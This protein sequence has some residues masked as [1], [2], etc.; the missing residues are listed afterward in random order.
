MDGESTLQ[1]Y[2]GQ[3]TVDYNGQGTSKKYPGSNQISFINEIDTSDKDLIEMEKQMNDMDKSP[4]AKTIFGAQILMNSKNPTDLELQKQST[5]TRK[6]SMETPISEPKAPTD[7]Q[8][9]MMPPGLR[10]PSKVAKN[11]F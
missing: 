7:N 5:S 3:G 1:T 10:S 6:Q 2:S 11:Y 9:I 8:L 4:M